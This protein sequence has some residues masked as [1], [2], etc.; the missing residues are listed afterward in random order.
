[1]VSLLWTS[2]AKIMDAASLG[3][4]MYSVVILTSWCWDKRVFSLKDAFKEGEMETKKDSCCGRSLVEI[5]SSAHL[6]KAVLLLLSSG[7][8]LASMLIV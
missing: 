3:K 8:S 2:L 4:C 1:M 5:M 7:T 6:G